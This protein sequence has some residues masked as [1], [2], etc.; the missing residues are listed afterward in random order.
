MADND[1]EDPQYPTSEAASAF[2]AWQRRR[3]T[4]AIRREFI[5]VRSERRLT[6]RRQTSLVAKF[7]R[8]AACALDAVQRPLLPLG[9]SA[10]S[11]PSLLTPDA[12]IA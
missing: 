2:A 6:Q 12:R 7:T 10:G 8:T 11:D 1:T 4:C 5:L 9:I 3:D